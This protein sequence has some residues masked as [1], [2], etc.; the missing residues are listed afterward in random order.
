MHKT[1]T[2]WSLQIKICFCYNFYS[3]HFFFIKSILMTASPS[4]KGPRDFHEL[5]GLMVIWFITPIP[6][7]HEYSYPQLAS[8]LHTCTRAWHFGAEAS[9]ADWRLKHTGANVSKRSLHSAS[10]YLQ[11][12]KYQNECECR[13]VLGWRTKSKGAMCARSVPIGIAKAKQEDCSLLKLQV[14]EYSCYFRC[15]YALSRKK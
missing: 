6:P 5:E 3:V 11:V 10:R 1:W 13:T 8:S 15:E 14:S 2:E 12:P 4:E 7:T 9:R